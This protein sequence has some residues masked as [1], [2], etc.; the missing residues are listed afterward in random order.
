MDA[1]CRHHINLSMI[2][3]FCGVVFNSG[4]MLSGCGEQP[5]VLTTAW[6]VWEFP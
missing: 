1:L 3:E 5:I 2:Y 6:F 4:A